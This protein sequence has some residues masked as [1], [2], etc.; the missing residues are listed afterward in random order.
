MHQYTLDGKIEKKTIMLP[1]AAPNVLFFAFFR[2]FHVF[3]IK[4]GPIFVF[5]FFSTPPPLKQKLCFHFHIL[6]LIVISVYNS[7]HLFIKEGGGG[8]RRKRKQILGQIL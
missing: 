2:S 7:I 8:L 3:V 5:F 1:A 6:I 4:F